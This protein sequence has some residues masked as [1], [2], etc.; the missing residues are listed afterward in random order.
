MKKKETI[1]IEIPKAKIRRSFH[2]RI[3]MFIMFLSLAILSV[4]A[5]L[6]ETRIFIDFIICLILAILFLIDIIILHK[7]F[8]GK[9]L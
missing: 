1:T 9:G 2:I 4:Y 7:R 3:A 8:R 5:G 6:R